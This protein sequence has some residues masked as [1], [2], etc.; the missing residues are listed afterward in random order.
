MTE[1]LKVIISASIEGLKQA[2]GEAKNQVKGLEQTSTTSSDKI[3]KAFSTIGKSLAVA[4]TAI[5]TAAVGAGKAV[6]D[7]AKQVSTTADTID[8]ASQRMKVNTTYYQELSYACEMNGVSMSAM[9][10]AAK[11]LQASG[12]DLNFEQ[13]MEQILSLADVEDRTALASQLFG[14]KVAYEMAP[15][16]NQGIEGFNALSE[17]AHNY[18]TIMNEETIAAGAGFNDS[19]AKLQATV[20]GAK[21]AL[22]GQMLPALTDITGGLAGMIAGVDG[23]EQQFSTGISAILKGIIDAVPQFIK[24]IQQVVDGI[25]TALLDNTDAIIET[26]ITLLVSLIGG[27]TEIIQKIL[28]AIPKI[29]TSI[30]NALLDALPTIIECGITLLVSLIK[31]LPTII[32]EI[33]GAMPTIIKN[34]ID[35]LIECIPLLI[36]AG[37]TLFIALI[38][39]LPEIIVE[40]VKAV[41]KILSAIVE[42][43][44]DGV[45]DMADAGVNLVEG[46]WD[47]LSSSVEWI[48][49]KIK[50][51]VGDVLA[52]IKNLF[53]I[54]SP[55]K[56]MAGY[57][58]FLVQGL[59]EGITDNTKYVTDAMEGISED[60]EDSFN[61]NL[62]L[63][64]I[65]TSD[66]EL[67]GT[68]TVRQKMKIETSEDWI[69][70]LADKLL[71]RNTEVNLVV[72]DKVLA[73]TTIE[74]INALTRSTGRLGL[75][76]S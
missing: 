33:C 14:E 42:A 34:V 29:I 74:S 13:A 45:S 3:K 60:I 75:A 16:L 37:V 1:E 17:E 8:K 50:E 52:F 5:A 47:G 76:L 72:N 54:H 10:K 51:W 22:V 4:G 31:A 19:L 61:P 68:T 48:K 40:I 66:L 70:A 71:E 73:Q 56:V 58:D 6:F 64:G 65:E 38:Q 67:N 18:G 32:R 30:V 63:P 21:T 27:L 69:S 11:Q 55:S 24:A 7:M 46:L 23:A 39:N 53:G 9:E 25:I 20:E 2:C 28:P 41:P 44:I 59:G 26:G 36:E 57:G 62:E 15:M 49:K 43:V 35:A 12:S